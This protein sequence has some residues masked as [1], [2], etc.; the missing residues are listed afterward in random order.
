MVTPKVAVK[1]ATLGKNDIIGEIAVLCD[2]PRTATV[3]AQS[4]LET[5]RIQGWVLPPGHPVPAGRHR[6]NERD[7]LAPAPHHAS[8]DRGARQARC[9]GQAQQ[10]RLSRPRACP[11]TGPSPNSAWGVLEAAWCC[12]HG[13]T[14]ARIRS[15]ARGDRL[16]APGLMPAPGQDLLSCN[17]RRAD[18]P[19]RGPG[20]RPAS[21]RGAHRRQ[22]CDPLSSTPRRSASTRTLELMEARA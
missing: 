19:C 12:R 17:R 20:A 13:R 22:A 14:C 15:G 16:V 21:P 5:L 10:R 11:R 8:P 6:G 3:V 2:V 4:A 9:A 18:R 7:R 1:V